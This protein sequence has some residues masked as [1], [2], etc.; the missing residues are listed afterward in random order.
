MEIPLGGDAIVAACSYRD[1]VP[2]VDHKLNL[3][4]QAVLTTVSWGLTVLLLVIAIWLG[5]RGRTSFY[6]LMVLAAAVGAFAEPLYDVAMM[7]YTSTPHQA[8][9]RTVAMWCSMP[10]R[11]SISLTRSPGKR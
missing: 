11:R 7:L 1:S 8:C 6:A 10:P 4:M 5:V 3:T 2:P 9:G